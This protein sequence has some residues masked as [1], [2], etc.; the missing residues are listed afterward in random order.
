MARRQPP[1]TRLPAQVEAGAALDRSPS[2][3][4]PCGGVDTNRV[5]ALSLCPHVRHSPGES[6][7][8]ARRSSRRSVP[9]GPMSLLPYRLRRWTAVCAVLLT[10]CAD[11]PTAPEPTPTTTRT[12]A[13][14]VKSATELFDRPWTM[15]DESARIAREEIAGYAGTIQE[16]DGAVTMLLADTTG[17]PQKLARFAGRLTTSLKAGQLRP[18]MRGRA[19]RYNFDQLLM[20]ERLIMARVPDDE[21]SLYDV[22]EVNNRV[23]VG[24]QSGAAVGRTRV[25][26]A[27]LGIPADAFSVVVRQRPALVRP[28]LIPC[29]DESCSGGGAPPVSGTPAQPC[30]TS[31]LTCLQSPIVAGL[32]IGF[33]D[34]PVGAPY[35]HAL[36]CSIGAVVQFA[37][38]TGILT[39]SHCST[40][41][42]GTLDNT[43]FYVGVYPSYPV[44]L[45]AQKT[46]DPQWRGLAVA[47]CRAG[48][49]CR[50]SDAQFAQFYNQWYNTPQGRGY[51]ARPVFADRLWADTLTA[52]QIVA[53]QGFR[54]TKVRNIPMVPI[55]VGLSVLKVGWRTGLTTGRVTE[56]CTSFNIDVIVDNF[57]LRLICQVGVESYFSG[58]PATTPYISQSGD[59]GA[60]VMSASPQSSPYDVILE[61]LLSTGMGGRNG[62][63]FSPMGNVIFELSPAP[64]GQSAFAFTPPGII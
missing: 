47:E 23:A 60:P 2:Q 3:N 17:T 41:K 1:K 29:E 59:S 26:V 18:K 49:L 55:P 51:V 10:A 44:A 6:T 63:Y 62:F 53:V 50:Y 61:G 21:I 13:L 35:S 20:W 42:P 45:T 19:V 8:V 30:T 46:K 58:S 64:V 16:A 11:A 54:I 12:A 52:R 25:L 37:G 14:A 4:V 48:T 33:P 43:P 28:A 34:G 31:T 7:H 38:N 15:D 5:R 56:T 22:D 9:Q 39:S 32:Q 57:P 27:Q 36:A 24:V 40:R